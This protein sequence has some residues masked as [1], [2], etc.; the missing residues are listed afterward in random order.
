MFPFK[1]SY[2]TNISMLVSDII[3]TNR[4]RTVITKPRKWCGHFRKPN[5]VVCI[6]YQSPGNTPKI[7]G[8]CELF[9]SYRF[10]CLFIYHTSMCVTFQNNN[11]FCNN[12]L[13]LEKKRRGRWS[14]GFLYCFNETLRNSKNKCKLLFVFYFW[15]PKKFLLAFKIIYKISLV[16]S[17][18]SL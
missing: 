13:S 4:V 7:D 2:Y 17:V 11:I 12:I 8:S 16:W 10:A 15:M 9:A 14:K 3:A 1:R 6:S 18:G 5:L